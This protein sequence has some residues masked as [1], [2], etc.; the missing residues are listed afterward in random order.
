MGKADRIR[1]RNAREKIAAQQA[2][3]RRAEARRRTF[4][5]VGS[6][7]AVLAV[8][9]VLVV[10]KGLSKPAKAA[11]IVATSASA[12]QREITTV[13]TATLNA[14]GKGG[15]SPLLPTEGKQ[16]LLTSDGKPEMLYMG[17]EYCPYC[18]AERWAMVVALSKFGT[19]SNLHFI[20]SSNTDVYPSTPTLTFYGSTYTSKYLDFVP[21]EL[22]STSEDIA[23]QTPTSE[24]SALM[25]KF[26]APPYTNE[27]GSFPF[28]DFGNQ[29]LIIGA[30]YVP[31]AL[32]HLSWGQVAADM[33]NPSSA[34][35]QDIDGSAN[36]II[37]AICK[38]TNDKPA[39]CSS[40]A[41][42][43]GEGLL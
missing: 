22:Y 40:S 38:I 24:Q 36:S 10:V 16:A 1:Q 7:L 12:V 29:Y 43:A 20:H 28:V 32:A 39:V 9:V 15:A 33:R 41:A 18:A 35:A 30:Q 21:V 3:A 5:A 13:P 23:L 11:A 4:L 25:S 31:G 17:A 42:K 19:F 8:V 37:G 14:V 27:T 34:V 6:V 2:A 26:D